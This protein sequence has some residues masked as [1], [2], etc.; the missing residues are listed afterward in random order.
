M[1]G[2]LMLKGE[3]VEWLMDGV[4]EG[5]IHRNI[6]RYLMDPYVVGNEPCESPEVDRGAIYLHGFAMT[7]DGSGNPD[8]DPAVW[9]L[10]DEEVHRR[11]DAW[12]HS[13][14]VWSQ[15]HGSTA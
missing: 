1:G 4:V 11:V 9:V 8:D 13:Y 14:A 3:V 15:E 10:D 12:K 7:H 2:L 6:A 5:R